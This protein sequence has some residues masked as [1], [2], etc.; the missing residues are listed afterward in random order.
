LN[1]AYLTQPK[2]LNKKTNA[3][4]NKIVEKTRGTIKPAW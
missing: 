3:E 2:K 1:S 4:I